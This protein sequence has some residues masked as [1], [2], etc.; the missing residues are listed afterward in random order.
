[1]LRKLVRIVLRINIV[2]YFN[3][4]VDASVLKSQDKGRGAAAEL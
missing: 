1:M 3:F 4:I 2:Q